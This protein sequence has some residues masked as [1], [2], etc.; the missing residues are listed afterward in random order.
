MTTNKMNTEKKGYVYVLTDGISDKY[1]IGCTTQSQVD[2]VKRYMT[3][4]P[5][6]NILVYCETPDFQSMEEYLLNELSDFRVVNAMG[7][8]SEWVEV[9]YNRILQ[10]IEKYKRLDKN[11]ISHDPTLWKHRKKRRKIIDNDEQDVVHIVKNID[12][13]KPKH[14]YPAFGTIHKCKHN[15]GYRIRI[16]HR[17]KDQYKG[18]EQYYMN[19]DTPLYDIAKKAFELGLSKIKIKKY[20]PKIGATKEETE[21]IINKI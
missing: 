4:I 6:V 10:E 2:L 1:K 3:H 20:L 13:D 12:F 17:P 5:Q 18:Y 21:Q 8:Q 9:S 19:E 15:G 7:S 11:T 16:T 14:K